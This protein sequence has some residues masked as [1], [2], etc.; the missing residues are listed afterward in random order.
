LRDILR[1]NN[2]TNTTNAQHG[3]SDNSTKAT[4]MGKINLVKR[5]E[6]ELEKRKRETNITNAMKAFQT[7]KFQSIRGTAEACGLHYSTLSHRLKGIIT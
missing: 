7:G 1:G 6:K 5:Q 3:G 2:A 4:D